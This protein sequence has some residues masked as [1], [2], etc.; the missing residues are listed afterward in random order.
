LRL[1]YLTSAGPRIVGLYLEDREQ[2]L[3][4]EAP[5]IELETESGIHQLF[6]GHRIW[7]APELAGWSYVPDSEGLKVVEVPGAITMRWERQGPGFAVELQVRLNEARAAVE[8]V[9]TLTNRHENF[10]RLALWG[11][12]ILPHGGVAYL[13]KAPG[14]AEVRWP[15]TATE[16]L[17]IKAQPT[18]VEVAGKPGPMTKVGVF[19]P[20]GL[21][22]YMRDDVLLLKRFEVQ[23]GEHPDNGCNVEVY[24]D[25]NYLELE[26]L[27]PLS[28]VPPGGSVCLRETW[29]L[30]S[31]TA[32]DRRLARL[33]RTGN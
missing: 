8:L 32:A 19:S 24:C 28:D 27:G 17:R 29:E 11:I 15:Y 10:Q 26:T 23:T 20:A 16:D 31:G 21:C 6:G 18:M 12:T 25:G 7:A 14:A 30:S 3:L 2:N 22:A 13:P 33:I 9:Q 1:D 5:T 4:G